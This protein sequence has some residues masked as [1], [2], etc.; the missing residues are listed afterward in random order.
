MLQSMGSQSGMNELL[1][2][3]MIPQ[4]CF[5]K[6]GCDFSTLGIESTMSI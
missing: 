1:N 6:L 2:N 5:K 4:V 3:N